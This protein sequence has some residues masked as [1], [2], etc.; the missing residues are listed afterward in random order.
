MVFLTLRFPS[1]GT[2]TA[3]VDLVMERGAEISQIKIVSS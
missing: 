2:V 1:G 3:A